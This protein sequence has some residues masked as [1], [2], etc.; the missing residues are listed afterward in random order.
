M[1]AEHNG[2]VL[3]YSFWLD[4]F[5]FDSIFYCVFFHVLCGK[6]S[7][8]D[9]VFDNCSS[10][11]LPPATGALKLIM[12]DRGRELLNRHDQFVW[13]GTFLTSPKDFVQTVTISVRV[14]E[15]RN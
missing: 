14:R 1:A 15:Y 2:T 7:G 10:F 8:K 11:P 6:F 9:V 13:D 4:I 3:R 5:P 12:T